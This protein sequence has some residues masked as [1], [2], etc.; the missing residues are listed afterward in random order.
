MQHPNPRYSRAA[1]CAADN[2]LSFGPFAKVATARAQSIPVSWGAANSRVR[3]LTEAIPVSSMSGA[4]SPLAERH[5]ID[6]KMAKLAGLVEF[7]N[8]HRV[9][10]VR[11]AVSGIAF[12]QFED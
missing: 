6:V 10:H 9:R 3:R 1:T 7:I 5:H 12:L 11:D 8:R 4:L 2:R